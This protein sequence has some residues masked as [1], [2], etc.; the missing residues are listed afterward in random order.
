MINTFLY[1]IGIDVVVLSCISGISI[2]PL[3]FILVASFV[4]HF[5]LYHRIFLYYVALSDVIN[6]I[7]YLFNIPISIHDFL[8]INIILAGITIAIAIISYVKDN[9]KLITSNNR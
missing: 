2:I 3:I 5:C 6:W 9:K 1:Y 4:F 8:A 7:D